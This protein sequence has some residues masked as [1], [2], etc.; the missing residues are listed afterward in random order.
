MP[1]Q[2]LDKAPVTEDDNFVNVD[3]DF[4]NYSN[5][6][7]RPLPMEEVEDYNIP[8]E[9]REEKKEPEKKE[10]KEEADKVTP[11]SAPITPPARPASK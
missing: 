3:P 8:E 7:D 9:Y 1:D 6:V 2:D 5:E 4:A 11:T 10:E